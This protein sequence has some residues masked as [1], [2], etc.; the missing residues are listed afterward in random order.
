MTPYHIVFNCPDHYSKKV[1]HLGVIFTKTSRSKK[2]NLI[3]QAGAELEWEWIYNESNSSNSTK[4][5]VGE[6]IKAILEGY[7]VNYLEDLEDK[8]YKHFIDNQKK[9][10]FSGII[11]TGPVITEMIKDGVRSAT[12][13][14]G[15]F[16][17]DP[18]KITEESVNNWL[19]PIKGHLRVS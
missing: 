2:T 18:Q 19:K 6:A 17:F 15:D 4:Y 12:Y 9:L 13:T 7:H 14:Y 10:D 8:L 3:V 11:W 16:S 1:D 5:T